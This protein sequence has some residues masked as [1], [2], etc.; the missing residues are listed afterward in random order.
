MYHRKVVAE[1]ILEQFPRALGD[2]DLF[3]R[4][5]DEISVAQED[6]MRSRALAFVS[7]RRQRQQDVIL[8]RRIAEAEL[9]PILEIADLEIVW[10]I[11][12]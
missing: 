4:V 8:A 10:A 9:T 2:P 1:M 6:T 7:P 11:A 12:R 5:L 3:I